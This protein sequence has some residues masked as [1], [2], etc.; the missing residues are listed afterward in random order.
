MNLKLVFRIFMV[1]Q[2]I[3][4]IG[5]IFLTKAWVEAAGFTATD[6][7]ITLGQAMGTALL[8]YGFLALRMP[9]I[10]GDRL[11]AIGQAFAVVNGFFVLLI[12]FHILNG[13][14]SGPTATGNVIVTAVLAVLFFLQSRKS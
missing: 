7:L 12:G 8:G 10:A 11:P 6:D 9:A 4:A 14:A 2:F 1:V 5:A 3:N 13:Q